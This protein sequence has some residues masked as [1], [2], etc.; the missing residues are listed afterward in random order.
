[1]S[2]RETT[3]KALA[4]MI[5]E[6]GEPTVDEMRFIAHVALELGLSDDENQ[7]VQSILQD[8]GK[9]DDLLPGITQKDMQLFLFRQVVAAALIDDHINESEHHF[10]N[11]AA[12]SFGIAE[13]LRNA[14]VAWMH[15]G[16]EWEKKGAALLA[17]MSEEA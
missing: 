12:D 9:F 14:F 2:E 10:I 3:C 16:M 17:A 4:A 5:K 11:K 7:G 1:M 13:E 8:G 15:E 6:G